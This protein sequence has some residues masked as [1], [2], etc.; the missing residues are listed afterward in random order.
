MI[1]F[2]YQAST[3]DLPFIALGSNNCLTSIKLQ[4]NVD[5]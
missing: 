1:H 4:L 5:T 2:N 3:P